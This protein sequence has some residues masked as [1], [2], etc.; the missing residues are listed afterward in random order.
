MH[1]VTLARTAQAACTMQTRPST[2][3]D[4]RCCKTQKQSRNEAW[5]R[6]V[7]AQMQCCAARLCLREGHMITLQMTDLEVHVL[8]AHCHWAGGECLCV[9][10]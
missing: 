2:V 10:D 7:A 6:Q 4:R 8:A 3:D 5:V 9:V 1:D